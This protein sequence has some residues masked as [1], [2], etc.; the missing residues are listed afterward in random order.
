MFVCR[1]VLKEVQLQTVETFMY[2]ILRVL[3]LIGMRE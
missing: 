2:S 1:T 3:S